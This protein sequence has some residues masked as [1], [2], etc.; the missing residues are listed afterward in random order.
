MYYLSWKKLWGGEKDAENVMHLLKWDK[1]CLTLSHG[2]KIMSDAFPHHTT[3][4][5]SYSTTHKNRGRE[6]LQKI[7]MNLIKVL[8]TATGQV[9]WTSIKECTC[10]QIKIC[11]YLTYKSQTIFSVLTM[12]NLMQR[13]IEVQTGTDTLGLCL[14]G[15]DYPLVTR[16]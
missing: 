4:R 7:A 14:C 15:I 16:L 11:R 10:L 1:A 2:R 5:K 13:L 3:F 9:V 8:K 12:L 6:T